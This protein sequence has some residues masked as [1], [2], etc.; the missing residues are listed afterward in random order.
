MDL[1]PFKHIIYHIHPYTPSCCLSN[2]LPSFLAFT[3][4]SIPRMILTSAPVVLLKTKKSLT[5][6]CSAVW[7]ESQPLTKGTNQNMSFKSSNKTYFG[8]NKHTSHL[9]GKRLVRIASIPG[10]GSFWPLRLQ[11]DVHQPTKKTWTTGAS[12]CFKKPSKKRWEMSRT[13]FFWK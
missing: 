12:E 1:Y 6:S 10:F 3:P 8:R 4:K 5:D 2:F 9:T 13:K 7:D 11:R